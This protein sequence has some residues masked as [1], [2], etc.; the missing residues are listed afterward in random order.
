MQGIT[1][2]C[3][4]LPWGGSDH[5]A[6]QLEVGFQTTPKNKPLRFEKFLIDHPTFKGKIK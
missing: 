2:D 6:L 5:W 4:I 3:N 1:L